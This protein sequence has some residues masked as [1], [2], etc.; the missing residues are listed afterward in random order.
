MMNDSTYSGRCFCGQVR[1]ELFAAPAFAC[2]CHCES[3][4]HAAGAPFVTWVSFDREAFALTSGTIAEYRSSPGVRRG[5]CA[6]CGTTIT[7]TWE[8]RPDEIDISV[9]SLD[10]TTGIEPAAH[11]WVEDKVAWLAI[12]DDLPQYTTTVSAGERVQSRSE[13]RT[14]NPEK[15]P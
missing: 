15:D 4:R 5:H 7:Y 10:D 11:I 13:N 6:A 12:N 1:F 9:A 8:Q 2:H 14:F 3:C